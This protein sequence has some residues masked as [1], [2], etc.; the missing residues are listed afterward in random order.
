MLLLLALCSRG[1]AGQSEPNLISTRQTH[2][3]IPFTVNRP[4]DNS[5]RAVEVLLYVSSDRGKSWQLAKR[6]SPEKCHFL[7][8]ANADG[9][10]W[11]MVRTLDQSG[12][13]RPKGPLKPGLCVNVDTTPPSL[14]LSAKQGEAGEITV[15]W[16]NRELNHKKDSLKIQY[17]V[18]KHGQWE[19]VAIVPELAETSQ[20]VRTGK[21]TWWPQANSG[22]LE[23]RAETC[24][25]AGNPAVTH[26][27]L[28]L[29]QRAAPD[30]SLN[31]TENATLGVNK[32]PAHSHR[33]KWR[34]SNAK[35]P[36][37]RWQAERPGQ[38]AAQSGDQ[39][40]AL[41]AN[42]NPAIGN[43]YSSVADSVGNRNTKKPRVVRSLKFEIDYDPTP[44]RSPNI[45]GVELWGTQDNGQ[46]WVSYGMDDDK[47][48]PILATV[49]G[50]GLYGFRVGFCNRLSA[51]SNPPKLGDRP[52]AVIKVETTPMQ[53]TNENSP[54]QPEENRPVIRNAHQISISSSSSSPAPRRYNFK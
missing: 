22:R 1:T 48:S 52:T 45:V 16:K 33:P 28:E 41:Q 36:Y 13:L 53:T 40:F 49:P 44:A 6:V 27:Q 47:Q 9:Q 32:I 2:F 19:S 7:F 38:N 26:T 29:G 5:Q 35:V 14:E 11:F 8:G 12:K 10:Y 15:Q 17:R 50:N 39:T 42:A 54:D 34:A 31:L 46:T 30:Q 37:S 18:G 23:I 43:R 20:P 21:V 3:S 51:K 24:D 4:D 25:L